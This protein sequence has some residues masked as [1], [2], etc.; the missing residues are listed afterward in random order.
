MNEK[1]T[2]EKTENLITTYM[3]RSLHASL[4]KHFCP[5]EACHEVKI[6]RFVAD[7]CSG[8]IVYEIQT[9]KLGNLAKKL[10]FYLESTDY[11]IVV[12]CPLAKNRRIIWLD[13]ASGEMVKVPRLSSKHENLA[14]GIADLHYLKDFLGNERLSFCFVSMEI[15]EVRLLDGYGKQKK[16]RATSVDRVAGE[17]YSFDYINNIEDVKNATLPLLPNGEFDRETL[18]KSLKL[19][20][21]KLWSAQ[22]LLLETGLISARKKGRKLIFEKI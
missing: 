19:K 1:F 4:K 13:E 9:A 6:G 10:K 18:S 16:I 2:A 17:I 22:K 12:V 8:G 5:D 21:M 11:Q 15:D 20:G 14:S 3:E 7:A